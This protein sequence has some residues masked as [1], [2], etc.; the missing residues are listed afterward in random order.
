MSIC[1]LQIY[2]SSNN[3]IT[4]LLKGE[5][6]LVDT[7][8]VDDCLVLSTNNRM[9]VSTIIHTSSR[10]IHVV[11]FYSFTILVM[12]V[13]LCRASLSTLHRYIRSL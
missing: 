5:V 13:R 6:T 12:L 10:L 3:K 4:I 9:R 11:F 1:F 7:D 8:L 2:D